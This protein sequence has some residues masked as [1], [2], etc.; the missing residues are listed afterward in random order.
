MSTSEI[1][2]L[3]RRNIIALL[4]FVVVGLAAATA[5]TLVR[6][7]TYEATSAAFVSTDAA[8][9]ITD[10]SQ[11]TSFT[12]Q[13]VKSYATVATS[14]IVLSPVAKALSIQGGARQLANQVT[15]T[16]PSDTVIIQ[17]VATD[18]VPRRA[19]DIANAVAAQLAAAVLDLSP[20]ATSGSAGIKI[21]RIQDA[22]PPTS[23]ASPNLPVNLLIGGVLGAL[24]G[25]S[26]L[27]LRDRLDTRI[28][29]SSDLALVSSAP[30]IGESLFDRDA[31]SQPLLM[32]AHEHVPYAESIR[33]IRTSLQ[34]FDT[35]ATSRAFV[36]TSAAPSEGKSTLCANLAVALSQS[37]ERVLVVDADLRRP[38]LS[39][40]FGVDSSVGLTDY[41][42][43]K[44][45]LEDVVQEWGQHGLR[46]LPSGPIPPNPSELLQSRA[47]ERLLAD[48]KSRFD[49]V[50]L[51]APPL[52]PVTDAAVL[53]KQVSGAIVVAASGR[54][55]GPQLAR[56]MDILDRLNAK[57]V[58]LVLTMVPANR[59][60]AYSY[61]YGY[62]SAGS[63]SNGP[64]SSDA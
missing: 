44:T 15:A 7:P 42:I 17:I 57:V 53:A 5:A 16:A 39:A 40:Y 63:T 38:R 45:P 31:G 12:Q 49:F 6:A 34:F 21:T 9:S 19:A 41:L 10:L 3:L 24:I 48:A 22:Q 35:D 27:Y 61:E 29:D 32:A 43:G 62:E 23:P 26:L 2:S 37:N 47:I 56:A 25:V 30:F 51:D 8:A 58:G 18:R 13:V 36:I 60:R 46:L 52:L 20:S 50:L 54:T 14:P 4:A 64:R 59:G 33:A 1:A 11:G 28:R 55:R